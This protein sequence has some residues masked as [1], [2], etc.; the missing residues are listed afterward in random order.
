V[1]LIRIG[2]IAD[3]DP[4]PNPLGFDDQKGESSQLKKLYFLDEKLRHIST[5]DVQAAG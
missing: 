2:L 1:L 4:D 5:K 3:P